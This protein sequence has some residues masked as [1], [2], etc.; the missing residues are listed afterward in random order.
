M[1]ETESTATVGAVR[2]FTTQTV[3]E[4]RLP[5]ASTTQT[6]I[7]LSVSRRSLALTVVAL[8]AGAPA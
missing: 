1:S 5:A 6:R 4:P 2:S 8:G 7:G 3:C